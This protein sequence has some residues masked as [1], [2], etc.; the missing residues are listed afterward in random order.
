MPERKFIM[1]AG[2]IF[3]RVLN[4]PLIASKA[5]GLV[6]KDPGPATQQRL[7][8]VIS[9]SFSAPATARARK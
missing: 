7:V 1:M 6:D 8:L 2:Y 5:F 9:A 4:P 3:L